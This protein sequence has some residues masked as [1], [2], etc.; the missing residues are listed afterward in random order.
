MKWDFHFRMEVVLVPILSR[1]ELQR[2]VGP[3]ANNSE[4]LRERRPAYSSRRLL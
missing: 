1:F 2:T 4:E 3:S